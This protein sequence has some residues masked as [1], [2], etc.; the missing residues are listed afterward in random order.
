VGEEG[1]WRR[2]VFW[3]SPFSRLAYKEYFEVLFGKEEKVLRFPSFRF[4]LPSGTA[5]YTIRGRYSLDSAP[6]LLPFFFL[7]LF[8]V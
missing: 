6:L 2:C 5:D 8:S 4:L 3:K 1:E 7:A